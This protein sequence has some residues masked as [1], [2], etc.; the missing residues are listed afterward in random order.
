MTPQ[1]TINGLLIQLHRL[2]AS[3]DTLILMQKTYRL[4]QRMFAGQFRGG[5]KPFVCHLVG[6]ASTMADYD[7]RPVLLV[8]SM[9]HAAFEF[10]EFPDGRFGGETPAHVAWLAKQIGAHATNLVATHNR[11]DFSPN[12]VAA[13]AEVAKQGR[14]GIDRDM[15]L[16]RLCNEVDDLSDGGSAFAAKRG[17]KMVPHGRNCAFLASNAGYPNLG[18]RLVRISEQSDDIDW[19]GDLQT[20]L[21]SYKVAPGALA[22]LRLRKDHARGQRVSMLSD[23]AT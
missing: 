14:P 3:P 4:A 1:Q 17:A 21:Y 7:R 12:A 19:A 8:A 11:T 2:G 15:L 18:D 23:A 16:M 22:Y 9:L 13:M 20:P 5:G 6:T 10:G